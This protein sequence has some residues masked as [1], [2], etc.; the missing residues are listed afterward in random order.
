[1]GTIFKNDESREKILE[2]YEVFKNKI[3]QPVESIEIN[4]SFGR[5][6]ILA[7]GAKDGVAVL[8]LHGAMASSAHVLSELQG[9]MTKHRV[10]SIDVIGQ[11]VKSEEKRIS[12]KN[13][14]YG[15]WLSE[16]IKKLKIEKANIIGVSWGGFAGIRA[17]VANPNMINKLVLLVPAGVING[18]PLAGITKLAIPMYLYKRKPNSKTLYNFTKNLLTTMDHD[19][20]QYMGEAFLCYNMDMTAPKLVLK[21][22]LLDFKS[23][24]FVV[25]ADGDISFPGNNLIAQAKNIFPNIVKTELLQ[26]SKHSR[27]RQT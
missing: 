2:W 16:I 26:N 7:G 23:P 20:V 5:T 15:A 3:T 14:D 8:L 24:T 4:T 17:A 19:W 6:H 18:K 1:M 10:Y 13:N 21:K 22:E 9:L 25:A 27:K 11:S 12:V